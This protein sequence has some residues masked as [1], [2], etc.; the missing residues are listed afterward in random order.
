MT[1]D[2]FIEALRKKRSKRWHLDKC[3]I[4]ERKRFWQVM[5]RCPLEVVAGFKYGKADDAA[6]HLGL[7]DYHSIIV[8][9]ADKRSD[10]ATQAQ[11]RLR[12]Q[13]LDALDLKEG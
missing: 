9:A 3:S 8:N 1:L 13:M 2:E 5:D 12:Q 6:F 10:Y 4:R 7:Q 11:A